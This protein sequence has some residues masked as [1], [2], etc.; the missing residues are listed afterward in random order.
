MLAVGP[1]SRRS[2]ENDS[3]WSYL[4]NKIRGVGMANGTVQMPLSEEGI[5][6]CES[7]LS[8]IRQ[9]IDDGAIVP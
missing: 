2:Y 4:M 3:N 7:E 6:L 8:A 9:W 5:V 1:A